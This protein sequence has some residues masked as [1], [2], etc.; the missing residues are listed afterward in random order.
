M[1]TTPLQAAAERALEILPVL[2]DKLDHARGEA[3]MSPER[4][5]VIEVV[6]ELVQALDVPKHPATA[7]LGRA[8]VGCTCG[9]A[10]GDRAPGRPKCTYCKRGV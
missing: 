3:G 5:E 10:Y 4:R 6:D 2:M 8:K 7:P 9:E 1:M